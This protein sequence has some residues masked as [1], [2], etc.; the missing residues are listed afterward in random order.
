MRSLERRFSRLAQK[1]TL[2]VLIV[3]ASALFAR[4]STYHP[5]PQPAITNEFSPVPPT[6]HGGYVR[7]RQDLKSYP[8]D[9]GAF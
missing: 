7:T 5:D 9:V 3:G 6:A 2:A 4:P 8:S 1:R